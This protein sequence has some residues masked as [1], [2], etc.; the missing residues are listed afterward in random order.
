MVSSEE[1]RLY[2]SV[3]LNRVAQSYI[4]AAGADAEAERAAEDF[5]LRLYCEHKIGCGVCPECRKVKQKNHV[6][7][8]EISSD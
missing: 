5:M 3:Y 8:L 1:L 4:F 6:D 2:R 7:I